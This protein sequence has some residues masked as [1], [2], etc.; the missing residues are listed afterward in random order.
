MINVKLKSDGNQFI[1]VSNTYQRVYVFDANTYA[2]EN[3]IYNQG[4]YTKTE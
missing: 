4:H 1:V 3:T 2:Y